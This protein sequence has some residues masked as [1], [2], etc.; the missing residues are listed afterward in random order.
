VSAFLEGA[1]GFGVVRT[2]QTKEVGRQGL[3]TAC[4]HNVPVGAGVSEGDGGAKERRGS[5]RDGGVGEPADTS[6]EEDVEVFGDSRDRLRRRG[7]PRAPGRAS[8]NGSSDTQIHAL[9]GGSTGRR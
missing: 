7:R 3:R 6:S 2:A 1:A 8:W 9:W 5:N 4:P